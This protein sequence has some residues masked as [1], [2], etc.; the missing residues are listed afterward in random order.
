MDRQGRLL[1]TEAEKETRWVEHFSEVLNRPPPTEAEV[2]Y[3]DTDL[4]VSTA[5]PEKEEIIAAI[6]SL[7][8]GKSPRQDSLNAKLFKAE[9]EFAAQ[10]LQP[11]FATMGGETTTRCL[12][13]R[14][15][16]E[17]SEERSLEQL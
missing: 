8:N 17:D 15:H 10:V 6:R 5:P 4:D 2:Q 1:T 3:P 9:P 14:C 12:G 11:L 16:C 13:V 7:K